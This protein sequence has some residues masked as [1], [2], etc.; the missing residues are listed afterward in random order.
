MITK[1]VF[2]TSNNYLSADITSF[3]LMAVIFFLIFRKLNIGITYASKYNSR[4]SNN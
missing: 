1:R 2:G 3:T 4:F